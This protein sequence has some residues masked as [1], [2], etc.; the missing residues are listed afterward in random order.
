MNYQGNIIFKDEWYGVR[1]EF[2]VD[3]PGEGGKLTGH[4]DSQYPSSPPS[5]YFEE[6]HIEDEDGNPTNLSP[7]LEEALESELLERLGEDD[8]YEFD[9]YLN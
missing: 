6:V 5:L 4:P 3:D 9:I 8:D 7:V 2:I 1:V